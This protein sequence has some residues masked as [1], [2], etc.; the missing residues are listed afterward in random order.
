[1]APVLDLKLEGKEEGDKDQVIR[2]SVNEPSGKKVSKTGSK[3]I[4]STI[5]PGGTSDGL[6]KVFK[7]IQAESE[8]KDKPSS[9]KK[10]KSWMKSLGF[11]GV[12]EKAL[13]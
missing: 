6:K 2:R 13:I 11:L 7:R 3:L 5:N 1:M 9:S 12:L 8:S 4:T 10:V